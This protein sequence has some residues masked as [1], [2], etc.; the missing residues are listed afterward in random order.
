MK[1]DQKVTILNVDDDEAGRY[2]VTRILRQADFDVR[3]ASN[4]REALQ[5]AEEQP[6]LIILDVNLPDISGFEVC[7]MIKSKP[8][9]AHIPVL[10]LSASY[11]N[12]ESKVRGLE[13]ADGYL[14]QPVEPPVL[15][16]T[17]NA[18]LRMKRAEKALRESEDLYRD[19]VEESEALICTHDLEGRILSVNQWASKFLGYARSSLLKMNIC[20]ILAPEAK[21]LFNNYLTTIRN[22]GTAKGLMLIQAKSGEKRIWEYNNSLRIEGVK[23]PIVRGIAFDVT[24]SKKKEE[25]LRMASER[26]RTTF[27]AMLDPV[28]IMSADGA[29]EQCNT[30]FA[31]FLGQAPQALIGQK[32]HQLIHKTEDHIPGCPIVRARQS[33]VREDMELS[34]GERTFLVVTDPVKTAAGKLTG[35]VHIMSDITGRKHAEQALHDSE[36][37]Y[38]LLAEI[39]ESFWLEPANRQVPGFTEHRDINRV[40]LATSLAPDGYLTI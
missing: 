22:E 24:E 4:G 8:S 1:N 10:H 6:D 26:W 14:T 40:M 19:L 11:L 34:I 2:A 23:V 38:R 30:A 15:I 27:D 9:T 35:F 37:R 39:I 12:N 20:D 32:C 16:A 25:A 21:D 13:N 33:G 5:L 7:R 17:V 31:S 29:V 3:E 28:A 36:E 18:L